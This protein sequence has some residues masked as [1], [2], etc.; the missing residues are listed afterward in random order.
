M[1]ADALRKLAL[2]RKNDSACGFT[3][4]V[5]VNHKEAVLMAEVTDRSK[6]LPEE[7]PS[8]WSSG[9]PP[10]RGVKR[11]ELRSASVSRI[12][13]PARE[14]KVFGEAD[15]IVVGGG[16]AGVSAA[17][18]ASRNGAK[19]ALI[20]RYGHLGGMATGG[21][22]TCIM[23]L[24]DGTEKQQIAG[25]CQEM[26]D[27][28]D[29]SGSVLH[30]GRDQ[31]GMAERSLVQAWRDFLFFT[32]EGRIRLS[33]L[34]DPEML[35]CIF[36]DMTEEAGVKL[37]L[38]S[39]GAQA[40]VKNNAMEGVVFQSKSGRQ[41]VLGKIVIDAT[42]D[43]DIF[44]D[45]GAEFDEKLDPGSRPAMLALCFLVGNVD[46]KKLS[47]FKRAEPQRHES[48]MHELGSLGGFTMYLRTWRE[49]VIWFNNYLPGLYAL[50]VD[51][52]TYVETNARKTM[53]LTLDFFKKNIPGFEKSFIIQTAAQIGTRSSRRLIGNYIVTERDLRSGV[54]H[55][56][57]I[58][59]VPPFM[60]HVSDQHPHMHIPY[61][62]LVPKS[63]DGLLVAGRCL[64]S[65]VVAN[66]LLAPIP[67]CMAMGQAA[68]TSAAICV[69][70]NITPREADYRALQMTLVEQGVPLPIEARG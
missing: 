68:G 61:R 25:L 19:T 14:V 57:A 27:R 38:H 48:L 52:L 47:E 32:V 53:L 13:E 33:A 60:G 21:L 5:E 59:V 35:K 22:V 43:G 37:L 63:I 4:H 10:A 64:S 1:E 26:I 12:V 49:D 18:A 23:P 58:A 29:S 56:D 24:S 34:V 65:D 55:Q 8:Y 39:W 28:L 7:W 54:V 69:R 30:P 66:S 31:V 20:E 11:N 17:V 6:L 45:A 9:G 16:P 42:G 40:I 3:A 51:D 67:S 36:N 70:E 15:V 50:D 44:A 41:A 62:A 46:T 2:N